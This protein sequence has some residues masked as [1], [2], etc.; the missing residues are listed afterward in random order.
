M[1]FLMRPEILYI[2]IILIALIFVVS[3]VTARKR[4]KKAYLKF[5]QIGTQIDI[6]GKEFAFAAKDHLNLHDLQFSL[7]RG[8]LTDAYVSSTKTL[9]LS[10]KVCNTA[11]ISSIAIVAHEIG[12]ALQDKNNNVLFKLSNIIKLITRFTNKFL[13][14]S[15]LT[16]L[17]LYTYQGVGSQIALTFLYVAAILFTLH[18]FNNLLLIPVEYGASSMALKFLKTHKVLTPKELDKA[19]YLLGIA[20][21]TYIVHFF[22]GMFNFSFKKK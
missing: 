7:S 3:V 11:S 4:M 5:M 2:G 20:A 13:L 21:K 17:A 16:S 15:L 14:P 9:I 1:L 12:H 8:T 10:E 19:R 22:D 6:T 18:V